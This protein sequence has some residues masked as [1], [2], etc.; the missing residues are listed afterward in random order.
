MFTKVS[1]FVLALL[2]YVVLYGTQ[3]N[4][5]LLV[6]GV[7]GLILSTIAINFKRLNFTW[8]HLLLPIIYIVS[9]AC[10]YSLIPNLVWQEVFLVFAALV[11]FLMEIRLGRESHLLQNLF[12][13]SSFGIFLGLF[14]LH[15]YL[16]LPTYIFVPLVFIASFILSV[17]GFTGFQ[18]PAK[19]YFYFLTAVITTEAAWGLTF[20]PTYYFV[21]AVVLFSVF[22][23]IWLFSFSAFFGKLS[24]AKIFWQLSLVG[25]L[26]I[27]VLSTAAWKPIG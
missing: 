22:Y 18:L 4:L 25:I 19:K 3:S 13:L 10:V 6:A 5:Y 27:V 11:F 9:V 1:S 21:N 14:A 8:P 16:Q 12:L 26:L 17:Q 7:F 23:I 20:W 24:R 15:Y 2:M